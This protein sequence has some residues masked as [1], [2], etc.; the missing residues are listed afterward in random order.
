M[1]VAEIRTVCLQGPS[2]LFC[3]SLVVL[4]V[5]MCQILLCHN[6]SSGSSTSNI[7]A[8]ITRI[9]VLRPNDRIRFFALHKSAMVYTW[10]R[11]LLELYTADTKKLNQSGNDW[12]IG[13]YAIWLRS[14]FSQDEFGG[15]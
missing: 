3:F 9:L 4:L 8:Q 14:Y 6:D 1:P 5:T 13:Y 2:I 11:S 15:M 10:R 12:S 7:I